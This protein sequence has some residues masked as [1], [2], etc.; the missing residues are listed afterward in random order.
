M[1]LS[2]IGWWQRQPPS[3]WEEWSNESVKGMGDPAITV[4][5][6][7]YGGFGVNDRPLEIGYIVRID[8]ARQ[9]TAATPW[10][11][12]K[13]GQVFVNGQLVLPEA[14]K[15]RLY[16]ADGQTEPICVFLNKID[17]QKFY[18]L[19]SY[20]RCVDFWNGILRK[21]YIPELTEQ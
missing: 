9:L 7:R 20:E 1:I 18:H 19:A 21:N 3:K 5:R 4:P 6:F 10:L 14:G 16:V 2:A 12:K 8:Y 11:S 13:R 15:L 17:S